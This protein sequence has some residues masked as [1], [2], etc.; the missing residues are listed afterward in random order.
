MSTE[1][2][3]AGLSSAYPLLKVMADHVEQILAGRHD[4]KI[5]EAKKNIVSTGQLQPYRLNNS[6]SNNI[7]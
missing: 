1:P 4:V 6:F 2:F 5:N 3:P 7:N